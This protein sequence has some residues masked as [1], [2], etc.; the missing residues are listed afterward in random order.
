MSQQINLFNPLFEAKKT[1]FSAVAMGQALLVLLVGLGGFGAW[2]HSGLA[3]L[4]AEAAAGAERLAQKQAQLQGIEAEFAPRKKDPALEEELAEAQVHL[5]ALRKVSGILSRGE[6]GDTQ[7]YGAYFR[8][9][10]RQH[11]G[12]VWLTAVQVDDAG[13]D[14][15]IRGRALDGAAVP[16]YLGKLTQEPLMQGKTFSSLRIEA[17]TSPGAAG[18]GDGTAAPFVEFSLRGRPEEPKQ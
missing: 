16:R 11:V 7:G 4:R 15:T 17:G 5:D 18:T 14:I 9:L 13:R 8:A 10:A 12:G 6:V 2:S 3:A 1:Y